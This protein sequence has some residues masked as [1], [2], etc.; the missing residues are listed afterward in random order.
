VCIL[1]TS[2][3]VPVGQFAGKLKNSLEE[4]GASTS[5]LDQGT[6]MRHLGRHAFSRIGY[7]CH[8]GFPVHELMRSRKLKVAGWLADQEVQLFLYAT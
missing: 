6:V 1:G 4:L 2:R 7:V 5:Y 8:L 3:N